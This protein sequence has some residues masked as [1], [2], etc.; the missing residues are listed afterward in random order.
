MSNPPTTPDAEILAQVENDLK[1]AAALVR[2]DI[3]KAHATFLTRL[4]SPGA[5]WTGAERVAIAAEARAANDCGFCAERK[6]ALSPYGL[7][8]AHQSADGSRDILPSAIIDAV[9]R[10]VTDAVRI[11]SKLAALVEEGGLTDAHYVEALGITV[12]MRSIDQTCRGLGAPLHDLPKAKPGAPS[13]HRPVDADNHASDAYVP[14]LPP[15]ALAAPNDD[16]W[17]GGF[18]PNVIRAMSLAPDAVRDLKTLSAAHY[19]DHG[20]LLDFSA[21]RTLTRPQIELIAGRVSS[22]NECFY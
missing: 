1:A 20:K 5:N 16:L 4:A 2:S 15:T 21:Q 12:C 3:I 22:I 6:M 14:M 8:G 11:T 17:D 13:G 18:V 10:F 19:L 7:D 9:H